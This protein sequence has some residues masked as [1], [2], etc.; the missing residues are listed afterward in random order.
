M[1]KR[2]PS[3]TKIAH[4]TR[5]IQ[6]FLFSLLNG[7]GE[8]RL[9]FMDGVTLRRLRNF[10]FMAARLIV[11]HRQWTA[12]CT[13]ALPLPSSCHR[14]TIPQRKRRK[15]PRTWSFS[16]GLWQRG[17]IVTNEPTERDYPNSA[18]HI[19]DNQF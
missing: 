16:N 6:F 11:R 9:R 17:D 4:R 7:N 8:L 2:T 1:G 13:G 3:W 19:I 14:I 12:K 5:A 18:K 10:G 15:S